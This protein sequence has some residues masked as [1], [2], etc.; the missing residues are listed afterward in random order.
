L[1]CR[2]LEGCARFRLKRA[3]QLQANTSGRLFF[4]SVS[5]V[6]TKEMNSSM[7]DENHIKIQAK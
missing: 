3:E 2:A 4:G 5:F 6:S 7:K 1:G